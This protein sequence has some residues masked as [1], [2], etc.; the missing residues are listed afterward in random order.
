MNR[1]PVAHVEKVSRGRAGSSVIKLTKGDEIHT[2]WTCTPE[3]KLVVREGRS[4][5]EIPVSAIKSGSTVSTGEQMFQ[6]VAKVI[7]SY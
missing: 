1:I 3:A 7:I 4:Q 5:K 6:D 2:I